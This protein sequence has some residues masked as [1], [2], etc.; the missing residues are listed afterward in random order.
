M[1][2]SQF[3]PYTNNG[4]TVAAVATPDKVVVACDS[5]ISQ[6]FNILSRN[7]CKVTQLTSTAVIATAGMV[8][9]AQN[10][11]KLLL[12]RVTLYKHH[13]HCEPSV[14]ALAKML[15]V[16]LYSKRFFPFYTFNLLAGIDEDGSGICFGYDAIGSFDELKYAVQGT[17]QQLLMPVL[18][19]QYKGANRTDE[20]QFTGNPVE[21][22]KEVFNSAAERDI[23]TGDSVMV[24]E[25]ARSGV[26]SHTVPLRA[27]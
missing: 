12:A 8:T 19:N 5:R 1:S 18:D 15:S 27:D 20:Y 13:H 16:T 7:Y 23:Y 2:K 4:G 10:L 26:Q 9:D 17:G 25:I 3:N 21:L 6:G 24:Y 14:R 22:L 11:H